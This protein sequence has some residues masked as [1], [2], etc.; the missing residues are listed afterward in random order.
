MMMMMMMMMMRVFRMWSLAIHRAYREVL[1]LI[2]AGGIHDIVGIAVLRFICPTEE[3]LQPNFIPIFIDPVKYRKTGSFRIVQFSRNFAVTIN[4]RKLKSAKYFQKI[5]HILLKLVLR[6]MGRIWL[7]FR[8]VP[9]S[10]AVRPVLCNYLKT[11][12]HYKPFD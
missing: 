3:N 11:I 2:F 10:L 1:I 7:Q 8:V 9:Y 6:N 12:C 5:V 4:P